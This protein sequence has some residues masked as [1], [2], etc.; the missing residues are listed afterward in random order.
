M[1]EA[2]EKITRCITG[3]AS[4]V[5]AVDMPGGVAANAWVLA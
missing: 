4:A 1:I 2:Q 5:I 3:V